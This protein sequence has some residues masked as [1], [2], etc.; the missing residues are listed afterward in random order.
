MTIKS[1]TVPILIMTLLL[2]NE[3]AVVEASAKTGEATEPSSH[4][5]SA[6]YLQLVD[7]RSYWHCQNL[8]RHTYCHKGGRLPQNWPPNSN[9]P[10]RS[11]LRNLR[12]VHHAHNGDHRC[13]GWCSWR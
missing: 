5:R 11:G 12:Q 8:P 4:L 2:I 10:E 6:S 9:T 3:F 1:R 7:A 13:C